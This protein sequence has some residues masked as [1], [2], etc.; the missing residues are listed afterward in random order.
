M[1]SITW[2]IT[3]LMFLSVLLTVL[4]L[5]YLANYQMTAHFRDYLAVQQPGMGHHGQ[6]AMAAAGTPERVFLE[7]IHRSLYWVGAVILVAG[8]AVSYLLAQS[9]TVPIRK[10]SAAAAAIAKGHYGRQ[11]TVPSGD[12]VGRLTAVFN[13][14]SRSLADADASR[15]RF[16]ADVAHELRTPLA[17]IQGNLEGMA[18]GVV[19]RSDEMLASLCEEAAHLNRLITD[20]RDLSLAEGGQ[21]VLEKEATDV[22]MLVLRAVSMLEPLAQEKGVTLVSEPGSVPVSVLDPRLINQVLYNLLTNSLRHTPSGGRVTVTTG[23]A[24]RQGR[25]W[26]RIAVADT[27]CGIDAADLPFVF[28]RFYRADRSRDRRSGGSG[29]GLAIVRELTEIHGGRVTAASEPGRG[30]TFTVFLPVKPK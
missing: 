14:M 17:I 15:R 21:L 5:V 9:I 16:L 10:L 1:P 29:L 13:L 6:A 27:G 4:V 22:N 12:E 7:S 25:N 2:R 11:V 28:D 8:L 20:L 18:E 19:E 30:S 24:V 3:G 26:L 23:A